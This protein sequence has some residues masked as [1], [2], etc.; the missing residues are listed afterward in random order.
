MQPV[1]DAPESAEAPKADA[2]DAK[3]EHCLIERVPPEYRDLQ[4]IPAF[5][6]G[7]ETEQIK[8]RYD[9]LEAALVLLLSGATDEAVLAIAPVKQRQFER[10]VD[11]LFQDHPEEDRIRGMEA[12]VYRVKKTSKQLKPAQRAPQRNALID[13]CPEVFQDIETWPPYDESQLEGERRKRFDKYVK[14]AKLLLAGQPIK[15][16]AKAAG[17]TVGQFRR[18]FSNAM[19][20]KENEGRIMG[21]EAFAG[22]ESATKRSTDFTKLLKRRAIVEERLVNWLNSR[23]RI[24]QLTQGELKAQFTVIVDEVVPEGEYPRNTD[25]YGRRPLWNWFL[26]SYLPRHKRVFNK[27]ELGK[28]LSDLADYGTEG[29]G[30]SERKTGPYR[31]WSCDE[32]TVDLKLRY[33]VASIFGGDDQIVLHRVPVL[34]VSECTWGNILSWR[35]VLAK[36]VSAEDICLAFYDAVAGQARVQQVFPDEI[37]TEAGGFPA[38]R[39]PSMRWVTCNLFKLDNALSHLAKSVQSTLQLIFG[40]KILMGKAATPKARAATEA[41]F[42]DLAMRLVKQLPEATGS[43]PKDPIRQAAL[44][45]VLGRLDVA[46][47]ENLL[48]CYFHNANGTAKAG[49]GQIPPLERLGRVIVKNQLGELVRVPAE[50][51]KPNWFSAPITRTVRASKDKRNPRENH[52]NWGVR[53]TSA[54]LQREKTMYATTITIRPNYGNLQTVVAFQGKT[55]YDELRAEG[56]WGYIPHDL[57]IRRLFNTLRYQGQLGERPQHR[58]LQ[59]LWKYLTEGARLDTTIAAKRAYVLKFLTEHIEELKLGQQDFDS[60]IRRLD[61]LASNDSI[62]TWQGDDE[63]EIW[64]DEDA[65]D[66]KQASAES[67]AAA[68]GRDPSGTHSPAVAPSS[69]P[70]KVVGSSGAEIKQFPVSQPGRSP[71][72]PSPAQPSSSWVAPAFKG[73]QPGN[74]DEDDDDLDMINAIRVPP[75]IKS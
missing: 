50:K 17:V 11:Q 23:H 70:L 47:F 56:I 27:H 35:L 34:V 62:A 19:T 72:A 10:L 44:R 73:T 15:V 69:A 24:N 36:Q 53:Y 12:F 49:A 1:I 6:G 14:G 61:D 59:A 3:D 66:G 40:S 8:T 4:G 18:V 54:K 32:Y 67:P 51:R 48:D 21:F 57:R 29:D 31:V 46:A 68:T 26:E 71:S 9:K 42:K 5:H 2:P 28:P 65:A 7:F 20:E 60:T 13:L 75:R 37:Y 74:D 55:F 16:A 25:D 33:D 30:Q 43:H 39:Y 52:V 45:G 22:W 63:T 64:D 41:H 38:N 58:P